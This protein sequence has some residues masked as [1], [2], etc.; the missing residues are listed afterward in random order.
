MLSK[1]SLL[2]LASL[3]VILFPPQSGNAEER[4][5]ITATTST[6]SADE[7]HSLDDAKTAL[8]SSQV[9]LEASETFESA[10]QGLE[11]PSLKPASEVDE[12]GVFLP[13]SDEAS[14]FPTVL[15]LGRLQNDLQEAELPPATLYSYDINGRQATTVYLEGLPLLTFVESSESSVEEET[16]RETPL[17]RAT[18]LTSKLNVLSR[19]DLEDREIGLDTENGYSITIDDEVLVNIDRNVALD[20]HNSYSS[21]ALA[22]TNRLRRLLQGAPPVGT[23]TVVPQSTIVP[24][25]VASSQRGLASWYGPGFAG[26]LSANGEI[27]DPEKLTAAHKYLPF[28]TMVEVVS[29]STGRSVVVRINDRGPYIGGRIIDLSAAAARSIGLMGAGVGPVE[30]RILR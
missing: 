30:I 27:F 7:S 16:I 28:G 9:Q 15:K 8:D 22:A 12:Q 19:A 1:S 3:G 4:P 13:P 14:P 24:N 20:L 25:S 23:A 2:L 5:A 17:E 11:T 6:V 18:Q 26:R 10:S 29:L 21:T